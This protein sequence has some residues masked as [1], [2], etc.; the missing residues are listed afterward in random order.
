MIE[1][2]IVLSIF[3]SIFIL[4]TVEVDIVLDMAHNKDLV[5]YQ[6]RYLWV[7]ILL[8]PFT[9]LAVLVVTGLFILVAML[10]LCYIVGE[11]YI[12]FL[13][14]LILS[15]TLKHHKWDTPYHRYKG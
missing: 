10:V 9:L 14:Q 5:T 12:I 11:Y 2:M 6:K 8:V 13:G 1:Y 3:L 7:N 4:L 15:A